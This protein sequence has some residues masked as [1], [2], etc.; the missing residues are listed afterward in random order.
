MAIKGA[1]LGDILGAQYEFDRPRNLD[2]KNVALV[3]GDAIGFTDDSVMALAVKKAIVEGAGGSGGSGAG[4]AAGADG[5]AGAECG[6]GDRGCVSSEALVKTMVA[7]GR[8]YPFCGYGGR[9]FKWINGD[10]HEPY[11]SWGN[12][13]AMRV[14]FVGEFYEDYE[15]MQ[16]MAEVTAAVSHDHPEG[17]KGAVVTATCI[18]MA[19]HGKSKQEIYDYV[20]EQYPK[21]D[22]EYSIA[23]SLD[24]IRPRYKWNE[25]CQ[26]SVP[27]AMRCFYE[28]S[29]YESFIRNVFSLKCDSDTFGAIAGGVAEEFYGGFGAIDADGLLKKYLTPELWEILVE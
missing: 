29:D 15:E 27:A 20:L 24:E 2:W 16:K 9:F 1:V 23:Y 22:Y 21:D 4:G 3:G 10:K 25:S 28:S 14:A 11:N 19:R 26:E 12:G 18:W 17:I 13:S 8:K 7:V 5:A 6:D